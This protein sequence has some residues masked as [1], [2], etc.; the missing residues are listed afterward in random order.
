MSE[1]KKI[2][3]VIDKK[4]TNLEKISGCISVFS[5]LTS[6]IKTD[7]IYEIQD[8]HDELG[9]LAAE[10]REW[11]KKINFHDEASTVNACFYIMDELIKTKKEV[12]RLY[13]KCLKD[14]QNKLDEI[15]KLSDNV[16]E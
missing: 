9:E 12:Q 1:D 4:E 5:K 8:Q 6:F 10:T 7:I 13:D 11:L 14:T 3:K 16:D 15:K 2:E